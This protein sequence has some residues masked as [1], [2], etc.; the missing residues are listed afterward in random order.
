MK[1]TASKQKPASKTSAPKM[2]AAYENIIRQALG[3][4]AQRP[5]SQ[6]GFRN[7]YCAGVG[8]E[9][10][11][12]CKEMLRLSYLEPFGFTTDGGSQYFRVTLRGMVNLG[13]G[14]EIISRALRTVQAAESGE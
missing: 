8:T 7:H 13:L 6:W 11:N 10:H 1:K 14:E 9:G 3:C 4:H 5:K 12:T 2:Q